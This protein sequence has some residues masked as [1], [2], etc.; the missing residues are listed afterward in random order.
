MRLVY[1][2]DIYLVIHYNLSE[3]HHASTVTVEH[4]FSCFKVLFWLLDRFI[5]WHTFT[6]TTLQILLLKV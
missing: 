3:G 4:N 6:F 2:F 5:T 1:I